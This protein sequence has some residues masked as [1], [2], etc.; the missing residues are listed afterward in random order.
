MARRQ[1]RRH[2]VGIWT[3]SPWTRPRPLWPKPAASYPAITEHSPTLPALFDGLR[4]AGMRRDDGGMFVYAS[5]G[6]VPHN[7]LL[8]TGATGSQ[9]TVPIANALLAR[10]QAY[11]VPGI[12]LRP[13]LM[14]R[15]CHTNEL[16]SGR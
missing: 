14:D 10:K 11:I 7:M 6:G 15:Q 13:S 1:D 5:L 16:S 8:D 2:A 12:F 3:P 9:I 4:K